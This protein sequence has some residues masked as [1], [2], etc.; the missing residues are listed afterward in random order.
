MAALNFDASGV[1]TET[2][3]E[4]VPA[5]DYVAFIEESEIKPTRANDGY[6]LQLVWQI[7]E[8]EHQ[9]RK[10]WHRI[11]VQN[12]SAKAEEIGQRELSAVCHATGRIKVGD[13]S[14]LHDIPCVL[15]VVQKPADGQY[16]AS[17]EVKRVSARNGAAPAASPQQGMFGG[18]PHGVTADA[19]G[20][21]PPDHRPAAAPQAAAVPPW[22][23]K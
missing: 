14:E 17:N 12:P 15:S 6:Y 18:A 16:S 7:C 9:G 13:S 21:P 8:G 19:A 23:R 22:Q 2:G 3:F 5:G 1:P 11:N 10:L 4:P 20:N